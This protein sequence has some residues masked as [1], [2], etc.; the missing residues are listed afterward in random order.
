VYVVDLAL[1]LRSWGMRWP[2]CMSGSG[3]LLV[4]R[5]CDTVVI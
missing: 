2:D 1:A 5:V 3:T 4:S